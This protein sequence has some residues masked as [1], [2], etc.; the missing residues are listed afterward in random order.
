[1]ARKPR[2]QS[3]ALADAMQFDLTLR[4]KDVIG[5]LVPITEPGVSDVHFEGKKWVKGARWEEIDEHFIFRHVTSKRG[6]PIEADLHYAPMVL[7]ELSLI[8]GV[9]VAEL[10]R[11]M[12]PA[13][14]PMIVSETK[15]RPWK[16]QSFRQRWRR[17]ADLAGHPEGDPQHGR[18]RRSDHGSHG[19]RRRASRTCGTPPP[20][21]TSP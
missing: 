9:P 3:I 2:L 5:E 10:R 16:A 1:M 20:T 21:A 12:L 14:G 6:K 19:C 8:A 7:E 4:Q 15:A 18:Q 13:S 17:L 11:D